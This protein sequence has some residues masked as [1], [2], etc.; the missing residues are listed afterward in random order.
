MIAKTTTSRTVDNALALPRSFSLTALKI[1]MGTVLVF[2][3][4]RR[5]V[6]LSSWSSVVSVM[7]EPEIIEGRIRG[8]LTLR[9]V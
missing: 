3:P 8:T 1:W 2:G 5:I 6:V 9:K 4:Y 7:T